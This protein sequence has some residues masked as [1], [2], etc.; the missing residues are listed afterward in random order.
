MLSRYAR[1]MVGVA[2]GKY[3]WTAYQWLQEKK[4]STDLVTL[5][6]NKISSSRKKECKRYYKKRCCFSFEILIK[7]WIIW[8]QGGKRTKDR[9]KQFGLNFFFSRSYHIISLL[10]L[11]YN[12]YS[13]VYTGAIAYSQRPKRLNNVLIF[14]KNS[15]S[16]RWKYT[17]RFSMYFLTQK[18]SNN[19]VL[20]PNLKYSLS[21]HF[22][23]FQLENLEA[24]TTPLP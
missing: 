5:V 3:L 13:S 15:E 10:W 18:M 22:L 16:C 14:R 6:K 7:S 12:F 2:R 21:L 1:F 19:C 8:R 20:Q 17:W 9:G 23:F 4:K 24:E 11:V